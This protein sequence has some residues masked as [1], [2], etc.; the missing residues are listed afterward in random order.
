MCVRVNN[1]D[2][3]GTRYAVVV[4]GGVI[5]EVLSKGGG[6][7]WHDTGFHWSKSFTGQQRAVKRM[8]W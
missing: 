2:Y 8:I 3:Y 5:L 4:G 1:Q 7:T 6:S